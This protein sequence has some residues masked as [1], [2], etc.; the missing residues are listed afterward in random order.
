MWGYAFN[1][2]NTDLAAGHLLYGLGLGYDLLYHDLT[3]AERDRYRA[4][5]ERQGKLMY[6]AFAPKPGRSWAY[7]QNHTFIPIAGLAIAAYAVEGEVPEAKQWAALSRAIFSR[8]LATYSQD[9]YY[10]E[11]YEYWI[12]AT[13]WIIHYLDAQKHATGENLFDQ[14]GLKLMDLYAAHSLAPGGMTPFDFGD[15]YAG[16]ESRAKKGDDY[17]RSHPVID[18]K[19]RY[20]TNYN[21]L[22][23]LAGRYHS[24]EIQ[25][26]ADW[27]KSLGH[28]SQEEWWTLA[29]RDDSLAALP[30]AKVPTSHLFPDHNVAYW[31]TDWSANA[32]AVAYKCGPPEGTSA[33]ATLAKYPDWHME[34]GHTHPDVNAFILWSHGQYL[35]GT[36][37]YAGVPRTD[38]AN[39]LLVDGNGQAHDGHGHDA[40]LGMPYSQL[41]GIRI[42]SSHFSPTGFDL[43]GEGASAYDAT[44]GVKHDARHIWL[45]S[46]N[47]LHVE[48][49]LEFASPHRFS[50]VLHTD[51]TFA[52]KGPERFTSTIGSQSLGVEVRSS[53]AGSAKAEPNIVMGPG[54]PGSVDKGTLEQRGER[55]VFTSETPSTKATFDWLLHF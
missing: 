39:T 1:K 9:G 50:E 49:Q 36:S 48:D 14:P 47:T 44:L 22:Y 27:M 32:T 8:V 5:L 2:P 30:M 51:T 16:P 37:G 12:F 41:A 6:A 3:S 25:G 55:L 24:T 20:E 45:N 13:P 19:T 35:T 10:Y 18:G 21:L 11:G 43:V 46:P 54:R 7:S 42:V 31:R 4:K 28:S 53:V 15:V 52:Q 26:V 17:D 38:E 40:W 34:A 29:W 33:E 23:D